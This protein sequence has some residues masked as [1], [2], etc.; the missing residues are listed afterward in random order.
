MEKTAVSHTVIVLCLAML[1][2]VVQLRA[3]TAQSQQ[4][5]AVGVQANGYAYFDSTRLW[6][7]VERPDNPVLQLLYR[8]PGHNAP[9]FLITFDDE[10]QTILRELTAG[11]YVL[12]RAYVGFDEL[13]VPRAKL[14]IWP[15]VVT[16]VGRFVARA[17]YPVAGNPGLTALTVVLDSQHATERFRQQHPEIAAGRPIYSDM[18][19]WRAT[20]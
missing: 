15:G 5:S 4:D 14:R 12:A 13:E 6:S 2:S 1:V 8:K 18:I 7:N 11:E 9:V 10:S 20:N 3:A 19:T 17:T 16:Y